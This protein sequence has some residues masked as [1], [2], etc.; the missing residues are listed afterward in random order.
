MVGW[1]QGN[2]CFRGGRE[3]EKQ[4]SCS[5][6]LTVPRQVGEGVTTTRGL[7]WGQYH[8]EEGIR[9]LIQ[10]IISQ[11]ACIL[12]LDSQGAATE[13]LRTLRK[14]Y[15]RFTIRRQALLSLFLPFYSSLSFSLAVQPEMLSGVLPTLP[16]DDVDGSTA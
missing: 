5:F 8:C 10:V 11:V 1:K 14:T 2:W 13:N 3:Q 12:V 4:H 6:G 9:A 15:I 16:F 7:F